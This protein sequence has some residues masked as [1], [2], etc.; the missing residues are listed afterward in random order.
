[1]IKNEILNFSKNKKEVI[2][3]IKILKKLKIIDNLLKFFLKREG[4]L[5]TQ[6]YNDVHL[7]H[8]KDGE[9]VNKYR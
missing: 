5:H 1:M 6:L 8:L 4:I 7:F 2:K 9:I 3:I